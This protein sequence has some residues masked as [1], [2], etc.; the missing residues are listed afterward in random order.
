MVSVGV[1]GL[2]AIYA[3]SMPF[4]REPPTPVVNVTIEPQPLP[5]ANEPPSGN[6]GEDEKPSSETTD[7][8]LTAEPEPTTPAYR[9]GEKTGE[10]LNDLWTETKGFGRGLWFALTEKEQ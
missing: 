6:D 3:V 7:E 2:F 8:L 4:L 10:K 1:L 9:T 5:E